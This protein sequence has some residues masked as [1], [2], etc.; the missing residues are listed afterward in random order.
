MLPLNTLPLPHT[1]TLTSVIEGIA[2]EASE[3]WSERVSGG[4]DGEEPSCVW[5]RRG[6]EGGGGETSHSPAPALPL[7]PIPQPARTAS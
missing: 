2:M 1:H 7:I 3:E 4:G 6:S 5:V